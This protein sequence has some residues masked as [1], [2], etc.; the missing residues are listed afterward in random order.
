MVRTV[1]QADLA[2]LAEV[3][4]SS[5]HSQDGWMWWLYPVLKAGIYED[6]RTRLHSRGPRYACLVAVKPTFKGQAI[7]ELIGRTTPTALSL[8]AGDLIVG[9]IEMNLKSPSFIQPWSTKYL[10]ISNLAVKVDYRRRGVAQQLLQT[11]ERIA[12]DWGYRDLYLHVL[13]NNHQARRLYWKT[14]YRL[15]RIEGNPLTFL[16]G[17][18]RQLLLHKRLDR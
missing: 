7:S 17:Q 10:Y 5:F 3:L 14:G 13:V 12:L 18:P 11:C 16:F 1:R 6:L 2:V 15:H 8:L 4:A 9:T